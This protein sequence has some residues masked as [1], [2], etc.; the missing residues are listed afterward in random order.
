MKN[1]NR[2][3]VLIGITLVALFILGVILIEVVNNYTI[4]RV[5][6]SEGLQI[7][8]TQESAD[9]FNIETK[10]SNLESLDTNQ[11]GATDERSMKEVF[12]T[13]VILGDSS[14]SGFLD[15]DLLN[16]TS[17]VSSIGIQ[18][19][20]VEEDIKRVVDLNPQMLFLSYGTNDLIANQGNVNTFI[21]DYEQLVLNLRNIL[22]NTKLFIVSILPVTQTAID[23][24]PS[25][26]Q[27]PAANEALRDLCDRRQI[28]FIDI[29]DLVSPTLYAEDGIHFQVGLYQAWLSRMKE[30]AVL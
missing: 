13:S 20:D 19:Q 25:L 11:A 26:A 15:Y 24:N 1:N 22:P 23:A 29:T 4:S 16:G 27:I 30:V 2:P 21:D 12:A 5:D 18:I 9:I 7:I 14:T 8:Q 17:V 10:L 6:T 3:I 28:A